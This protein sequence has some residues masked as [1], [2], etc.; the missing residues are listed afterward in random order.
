[1]KYYVANRVFIAMF[2]AGSIFRL[3]GAGRM[4]P[5]GYTLDAF[6]IL[7]LVM[8]IGAIV[9]LLTFHRCPHCRKFLNSNFLTVACKN[10]G[11]ELKKD[12]K[13]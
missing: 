11:E 10:C 3:V 7:G 6:T 9:I 5:P 8:Y 1:M 13:K 4:E 2:F 12:A